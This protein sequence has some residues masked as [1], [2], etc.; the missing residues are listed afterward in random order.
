M[1][2]MSVLSLNLIKQFPR[3]EVVLNI[4]PEGKLNT[5]KIWVDHL[6][7]SRQRLFDATTGRF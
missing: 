6:T 2:S 7:L 1:A 4:L 5:Q 3:E